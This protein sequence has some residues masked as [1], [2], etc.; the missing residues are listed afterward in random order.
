MENLWEKKK[1]G[2]Q[3]RFGCSVVKNVLKDVGLKSLREKS[4]FWVGLNMFGNV[5]QTVNWDVGWYI[6][7]QTV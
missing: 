1:R 2:Y 3:K 4:K 6:Y 5:S 7:M